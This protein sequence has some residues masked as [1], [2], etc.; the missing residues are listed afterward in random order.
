MVLATKGGIEPKL[1]LDILDNSAAKSGLISFKAPFVFRGDFRANF[2]VKW[3]HK[4]IGLM[5]DSGKELGVP[6]VLTAVT[7]Q[8]FQAAVAE[9][10][11]DE[12]ICSTIRVL[13]DLAGVQVRAQ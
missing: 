6:L 3:M 9:G 10:H 1:M 4:D 13:E 12:D 5:L 8:L 2:S 7:S 11:A